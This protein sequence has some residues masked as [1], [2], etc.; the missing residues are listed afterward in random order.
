MIK[1]NYA[2]TSN[3]FQTDTSASYRIFTPTTHQPLPYHIC[4][5]LLTRRNGIKNA[6][7]ALIL[8]LSPSSSISLI[9]SWSAIHL[10]K[11]IALWIISFQVS[12]PQPFMC[13]FIQHIRRNTRAR[14]CV[15][16]RTQISLPRYE[17][18]KGVSFV[19]LKSFLTLDRSLRV[20]N[21]RAKMNDG[22]VWAR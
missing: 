15:C 1:N 21:I 7:L 22:H 9:F 20:W 5:Y 2:R 10:K 13:V 18:K 4:C 6:P 19:N 3:K 14:A 12:F 11:L 17:Q 8:A 16:V